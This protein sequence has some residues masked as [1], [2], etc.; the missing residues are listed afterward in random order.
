MLSLRLAVH[1][2][3]QVPLSFEL[4]EMAS[5]DLI[6]ATIKNIILDAKYKSETL[7]T[8]TL[9]NIIRQSIAGNWTQEHQSIHTYLKVMVDD[10]V[11]V[12]LAQDENME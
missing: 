7:R 10:V 8:W 5:M 3:N 12:A 1:W 9:E 2:K 4:V 11:A 6:D